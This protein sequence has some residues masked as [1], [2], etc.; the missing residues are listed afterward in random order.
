MF[1]D[2]LIDIYSIS[3]LLARNSKFFVTG[4]CGFKIKVS[5]YQLL[6]STYK[7]YRLDVKTDGE[8]RGFVNVRDFVYNPTLVR[9]KE[10]LYTKKS[11]N[12]YYKF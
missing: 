3:V 7:V 9:T 2:I 4:F 11:F 8:K 12:G 1:L 10:K 5:G 6:V